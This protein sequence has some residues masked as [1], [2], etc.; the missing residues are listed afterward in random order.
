MSL[1]PVFINI[2]FED[3]L[4]ESVIERLLQLSPLNP[5]I[6]RRINGRG[7]GYIRSRIQSFFSAAMHQQTFLVL[8]D[9]DKED[10]ALHLINSLV[11]F[12]K[13]NKR[14]L[15][16][17]AIRE[18]EAWLLADYKGASKFLGINERLIERNPETLADPKGHLIQ[19]AQKSRK[20]DISKTIPPKPGTSSLIG[21]EYN[22]TLLP[23]VRNIWDIHAA[24]KRSESLRRAIEA[25]I[26][27]RP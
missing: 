27:F 24:A 7:C 17:I 18:V 13:R 26:T 6:V 22:Q 4:S 8:M 20:K 19:L 23:F 12:D 1:K 15:F 10:C 25:V 3:S 9:S 11:P 16:R 14:C 2:V 21:P 5:Q